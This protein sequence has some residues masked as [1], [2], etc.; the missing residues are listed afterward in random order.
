VKE[1]GEFIMLHVEHIKNIIF[2][3]LKEGRAPAIA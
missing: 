3:A 2:L 1:G